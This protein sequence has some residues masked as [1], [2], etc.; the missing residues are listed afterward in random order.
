MHRPGFPGHFLVPDPIF[1]CS[2]GHPLVLPELYENYFFHPLEFHLTPFG[3]CQKRQKDGGVS[4][5]SGILLVPYYLTIPNT[6]PPTFC[7]R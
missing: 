3:K 2:H 7:S 5:I 4:G 1:L 6:I